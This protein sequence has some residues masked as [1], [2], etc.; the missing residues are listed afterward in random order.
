MFFLITTLRYYL[1]DVYQLQHIV[2]S[3]LF[4]YYFETWTPNKFI[5]TAIVFV[6]LVDI[7]Y[8]VP[9][10]QRYWLLL[11]VSI[12]PY[13]IWTFIVIF[14][15]RIKYDFVNIFPKKKSEIFFWSPHTLAKKLR[16]PIRIRHTPNFAY[17]YF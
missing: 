5:H 12:L 6:C 10:T 14:I 3:Y 9:V 7:R 13:Y 4:T 17:P 15:V 16:I 8:L 2:Y 11:V 1:Y